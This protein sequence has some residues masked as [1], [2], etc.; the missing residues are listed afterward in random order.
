VS[1]CAAAAPGAVLARRALVPALQPAEMVSSM[2]DADDT[3]AAR[4]ALLRRRAAALGLA[5]SALFPK[6]MHRV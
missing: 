1:A 5:G 2:A 6:A 4:E 3:V